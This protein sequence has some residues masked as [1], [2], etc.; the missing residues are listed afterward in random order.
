MN[1]PDSPA[2]AEI[3]LARF[4]EG[5]GVQDCCTVLEKA[6]IA[7]R[8]SSDVPAFDISSV[9]QGSVNG[10]VIVMVAAADE[11]RA[12]ETLLNDARLALQGNEVPAD[13][14]LREWLDEDLLEVVQEPM[15]WSAYDVAAAERLLKERGVT[16]APPSY[17]VPEKVVQKRAEK[18]RSLK[19]FNRTVL[20]HFGIGLCLAIA[21]VVLSQIMGEEGR[22]YLRGLR[23]F[24]F[25]WLAFLMWPSKES[26]AED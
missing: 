18:A 6:G 5:E 24:T 22:P 26:E 11:R 21:Y 4:R 23:V 15:E 2:E 17:E 14:H 16:F 7:Y 13:Y 12:R 9:G 8:L 19:L 3:E 20:I 10:S 25:V 1:E